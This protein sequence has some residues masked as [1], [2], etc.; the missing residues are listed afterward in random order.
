MTSYVI[1][2]AFQTVSLV[3]YERFR[4]SKAPDRSQFLNFLILTVTE[5]PR[6]ITVFERSKMLMERSCKRPGTVNGYKRLETNS[7]KSWRF[8]NERSIA[9]NVISWLFSKKIFPTMFRKYQTIFLRS[10]I[11]LISYK[12]MQQ[13]AFKVRWFFSFWNV[14][15]PST[16]STI[17]SKALLRPGAR[18]FQAVCMNVLWTTTDIFNLFIDTLFH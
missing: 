17:R 4:P 11:D 5:R 13:K 9:R 1:L 8:K 16:F 3:Q 18:A 12:L 7:G 10:L 14:N 6:F 15:V 2:Q